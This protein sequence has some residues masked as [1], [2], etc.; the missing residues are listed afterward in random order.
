MLATFAIW[1]LVANLI[2]GGLYVWDKRSAGKD[3]RRVSEKTLLM[4]SL[5]GGWPGGLITGKWI[6]HKTQKTS[7]RIK[8]FIAAII[9]IATCTGLWYFTR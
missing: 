8:F 1:T 4:W 2:T 7:Y 6:R 9:N 3:R 5:L